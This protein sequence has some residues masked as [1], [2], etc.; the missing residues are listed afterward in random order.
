MLLESA[1][2]GESY[3]TLNFLDEIY[4]TEVAYIPYFKLGCI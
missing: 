1:T 4:Q 2:V 3:S